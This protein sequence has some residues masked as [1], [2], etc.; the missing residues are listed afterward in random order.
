MKH[1]LFAIFFSANLFIFYSCNSQ[2]SGVPSQ[3]KDLPEG[4]YAEFTTPTGVILVQ[5]EYQKVPMTV[6]NFVALAE[7]KMK[8]TAKGMDTPFYDGLKFHRVISKANGDQQDF[9]I[10]GGDPQGTGSGGPGYSFADE[11]TDLKHDKPGILSMAN[12]GPATNGSQFFI[13]IV[14][15][16]WLDGKHT[17]FG[18]VVQGQDVVNSLKQGTEMKTVK[19]YR[20]GK[21]AKEF[22]AVKI[23]DEKTAAARKQQEEETKI[24]SM[25]IEQLVSEK[26]P[27]AT[28]T[29]SG[30]YYIMEREGTGEQAVSGKTVSVHYNGTLA[31]GKKFDASY[32]RGEPIEFP[33][34]QGMVIPGWEEGIALLKVGGKA[35]LIIPYNLAYGEQGR[36]PIIPGK[37]NLIFDVELLGVK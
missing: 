9:M 37:A 35:K 36:P 18:H 1:I 19:I 10:Q 20:I 7:G 28:K 14:A 16:P 2:K 5:L 23:F 15:T 21:E 3:Y 22:D 33:L 8:N 31:S 4:I 32:D 34:G 11:I 27:T 12:S 13:T 17:V 24:V 26:F 30:L 6:A 25:A 29:A